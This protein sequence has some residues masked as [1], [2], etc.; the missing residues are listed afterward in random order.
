[1]QVSSLLN[2]DER[3]ELHDDDR[4]VPKT[5]WVFTS[6]T[7]QWYTWHETI[8]VPKKKRPTSPLPHNLLKPAVRIFSDDNVE[9]LKHHYKRNQYPS[10][11]KREQLAAKFGTTP[12][13]IQIWFQN[14]RAREARS[15][16]QMKDAFP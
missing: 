16:P 3:H 4:D 15:R 8:D 11:N 6:P 5:A 9:E 13:Q 10:V 7:Q 14:K 2:D 1:M 12:R